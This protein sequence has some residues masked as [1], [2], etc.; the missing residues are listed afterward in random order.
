MFS[1][2]YFEVILTAVAWSWYGKISYMIYS[3]NLHLLPLA[4]IMLKNWYETKSSM[5]TGIASEVEL[6]RNFFDLGSAMLVVL[7]FWMPSQYT[8]FDPAV[9]IQQISE[10]SRSPENANVFT[11]AAQNMGV[12]SSAAVAVPPGWYAL[13]Y[14]MK[15][16]M[17]Q[18]KEWTGY[19][20]NGTAMLNVYNNLDIKD[21]AIRSESDM[22][23]SSC[24]IPALKRYQ[25][26]NRP[27]PPIDPADL[28][29]IGNDVFVNTPGFYQACTQAQTDDGSCF[30]PVL[31]M[32]LKF[33]EQAG[34]QTEFSIMEN[35]APVIDRYGRPLRKL[36]TPSCKQW[37]NASYDNHYMGGS[38]PSNDFDGLRQ[39][40]Y[41]Q[42]AYSSMSLHSTSAM[43]EMDWFKGQDY[44]AYL[45]WASDQ[46]GLTDEETKDNLVKRMLQL[47]APS[48]LINQNDDTPVAADGIKGWAQKAYDWTQELF[49]GFGAA[50]QSMVLGAMH[51][52]LRPGLEMLQAGMLFGMILFSSI[53]LPIALFSLEAVIKHGMM[54]LGILML[55]LLW[56]LA[57]VM[58]EGL[59]K[60]FYPN[61]SILADMK[62][63]G[64]SFIFMIFLLGLYI[65][66]PIMFTR[67]MTAAGYDAG[68]KF[69]DFAGDFKD[70]GSKGAGMGASA[71]NKGKKLGKK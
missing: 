56:H 57:D 25:N 51:E 29:Y 58:N 62:V 54:L 36:S 7:L 8:K 18:L 12:D 39:K 15:G 52:V 70:A 47:D 37:W 10:Q 68:I 11:S 6:R 69:N 65:L 43:N 21:A 64:E 5:E 26:A 60:V 13:L 3:L 9:H 45:G 44:A 34:I 71:A 2:N 28:N 19:L 31:S 59:V 35:G 67:M 53:S 14:G 4:I 46:L 48:Y 49:G 55:P 38:V 40:L 23:F 20:P 66:L 30:G 61:A 24:Y 27:V 63:S 32:P 41:E 42:A 17:N 16:V 22:F 50:Y 1:D 33:A